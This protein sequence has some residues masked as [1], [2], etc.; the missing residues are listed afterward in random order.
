MGGHYDEVKSPLA[1][2]LRNFACCLARQKDPGT[3]CGRKLGFQKEF[4]FAACKVQMLLSDFVTWSRVKFESVV[5][6]EVADV[7][8]GHF[9]SENRRS[10]FHIGGH[11]DAGKREVDREQN[12]LNHLSV[13]AGKGE[14][15]S[16]HQS[17]PC[18][19][20]SSER[21]VLLNCLNGSSPFTAWDCICSGVRFGFA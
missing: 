1:S 17:F 3:L 11:S 7:N 8:Q 14:V 15:P 4:K 19:D 20:S 21:Q 10:S 18:S 16:I 5:A 2:N 12:L 13:L 6:A 9:C